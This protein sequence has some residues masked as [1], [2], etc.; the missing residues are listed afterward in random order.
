MPHSHSMRCWRLLTWLLRQDAKRTH[1]NKAVHLSGLS[2]WGTYRQSCIVKGD[3]ISNRRDGGIS[4]DGIHELYE[5]RDSGAGERKE[6]KDGRNE[7][8]DHYGLYLSNAI[9]GLDEP[10][11][12]DC[13]QRQRRCR[14]RH[15]FWNERSKDGECA[16]TSHVALSAR[17][18]GCGRGTCGQD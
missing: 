7:V 16:C 17:V 8:V 11:H 6:H 2:G 5:E 14:N 9:D 4:L 3:P 18:S 12:A 13:R 1:L 10:E 15:K